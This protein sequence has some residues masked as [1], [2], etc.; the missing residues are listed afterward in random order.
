MRTMWDTRGTTPL[1]R[2]EDL[3]LPAWAGVEAYTN[4]P[5]ENALVIYTNGAG[6]VSEVFRGK[7]WLE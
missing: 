1:E 6:D 3:R 4:L 7:V 2:A 5:G